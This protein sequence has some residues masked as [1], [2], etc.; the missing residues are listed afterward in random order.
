MPLGPVEEA[1]ECF[2][3]LLG[4]SLPEFFPSSPLLLQDMTIR[5]DGAA[6]GSL[7]YF[8]LAPRS[9]SAAEIAAYSSYDEYVKEIKNI[10][11]PFGF[12]PSEII[13]TIAG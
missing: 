9:L 3:M 6:H 4:K 11:G 7:R 5:H 8:D 10:I 1:V 13:L 12:Y 2:L